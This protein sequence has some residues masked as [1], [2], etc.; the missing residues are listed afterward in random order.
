MRTPV[1]QFHRKARKDGYNPPF[2]LS[3]ALGRFIGKRRERRLFITELHVLRAK[4]ADCD[5]TS[6]ANAAL[7]QLVMT[8]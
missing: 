7:R 1:N 8:G 6:S 3:S 2:W 5:P 4:E